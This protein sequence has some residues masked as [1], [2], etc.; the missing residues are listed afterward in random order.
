MAK[1]NHTDS[2][3]PYC[4]NC[5]WRSG[6]DSNGNHYRADIHKYRPQFYIGFLVEEETTEDE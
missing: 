3:Y 6:V 4:T 1:T 2:Y 5:S